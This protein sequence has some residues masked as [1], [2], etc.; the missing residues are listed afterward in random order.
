[1]GFI[2]KKN[3]KYSEIL[4]TLYSWWRGSFYCGYFRRQQ[5]RPSIWNC[6][7]G[8]IRNIKKNIISTP[9][10]IQFFIQYHEHSKTIV[11]I[12]KN[13]YGRKSNTFGNCQHASGRIITLEPLESKI[14]DI[15]SA[16]IH[17]RD[18]YP[19]LW[20]LKEEAESKCKI[21]IN[22][23]KNIVN[24]IDLRISSELERK[25]DTTNTQL[26]RKQSLFSSKREYPVSC[27]YDDVVPEIVDEIK[28]RLDG[29]MEARLELDF[30]FEPTG[31]ATTGDLTMR[32]LSF[33][34]NGKKLCQVRESEYDEIKCRIERLL[35]DIQLKKKISKV[36]DLKNDLETNENRTKFINMI[37]DLWDKIYLESQS[38]NRKAKC[39]LCPFKEY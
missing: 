19:E 38:L 35:D 24:E 37:D 28:M 13:G 11:E 21:K 33:G 14:A 12:I 25:I 30:K 27:Y 23:I 7:P 34:K 15:G 8:H 22:E 1:M 10:R 17:L 4:G 20:K 39:P 31:S 26:V 6:Y 36:F 16:R 9:G 18:G 5:I 3:Y 29:K 32:I 2:Y